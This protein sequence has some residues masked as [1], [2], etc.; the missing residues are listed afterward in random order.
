MTTKYI[1]N[2]IEKTKV[3]N[4]ITLD[5]AKAQLR[6][7]EDFYDDDTFI[8]GLIS[9]AQ[10]ITEKYCSIDISATDNTAVIYNFVGLS[11]K[12]TEVPFVEMT[13]IQYRDDEDAL[14]DVP[15]NYIVEKRS[16]FFTL[17]F[18]DSI[19]Y[20]ELVV[21]FK[22]G[23][24]QGSCPKNIKRAMLVKISDLYDTE[25]SGF[26]YSGSD[27]LETFERLLTGSLIERF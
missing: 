21:K 22:T 11:L 4:H 15:T 9:D 5:E 23:Y 18:D 20:S 3:Y 10:D 6:V 7:E 25:R 13:S 16:S 1:R 27:R 2:I 14:V 8:E 26:A 12:F 19:T 17:H 24:A